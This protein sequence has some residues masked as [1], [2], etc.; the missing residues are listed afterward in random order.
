M[1]NNKHFSLLLRWGTGLKSKAFE[2]GTQLKSNAF[3]GGTA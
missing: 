2:G 3:G 1:R